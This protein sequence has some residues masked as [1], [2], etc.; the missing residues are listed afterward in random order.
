MNN[1]VKVPSIEYYEQLINTISNIRNREYFLKLIN[2]IKNQKGMATPNQFHTLQKLKIGGLE[3]ANPSTHYKERKQERGTITDIYL[4]EPAYDGYDKEDTK[5]KLIKEIQ[6]ELNSRLS[7]IENKDISTSYKNNVIIKVLKPVLVNKNKDYVVK[8]FYKDN[9]GVDKSGYMYY[10]IVR[11][12][13]II[14]LLVDRNENENDENLIQSSKDHLNRIGGPTDR[15]FTV[16]QK[17]SYK[18]DIDQVHGKEKELQL[19]QAPDESTVNYVPR[20]DYRKGASF[21]DDQYG[22]GTIVNTA[23]GVKGQGDANGRVDWVD[24]D[25][26]GKGFLVKDKSGKPV[27]TT[28]RRI[29]PVFT[30]V[31]FNTHKQLGV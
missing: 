17:P 21:T 3:E 28:V 12:N 7:I 18:I 19:R 23:S 25:F 16:S 11:D 13:V 9:E 29:A 6:K 10:V 31:H 22:T 4:P 30:K 2:S 1:A 5:S 15:P 27:H 20:T 14:T 8:I 26:G 24:V